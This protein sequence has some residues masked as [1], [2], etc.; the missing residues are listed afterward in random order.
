MSSKSRRQ[1]G[2]FPFAT[3]DP[4]PHWVHR[5]LLSIVLPVYNH[6]RFLREAIESVLRPSQYPLELIVINDGSTDPAV[7]DILRA[8][9]SR[10][11][12][13]VLR[14]PNRG[15]AR[16]LNRGFAEAQGSLLGWTSADNRYL[17]GALDRMADFLVANPGIGLV[18][19]N[20]QLI[21]E[22][23]LPAKASSYRPQDQDPAETSVLLLPHAA[24]TLDALND[25][26]VNACV[27]FRADCAYLAGPL[28]ARHHGYED[29]DHWLRLLRFRPFAHLPSEE[30]Y[31]QYRLHRESLT[32]ELDSS[33]L[34]QAQLTVVEH[35]R[36]VRQAL[37]QSL[38]FQI[39][40]TEREEALAETVARALREAGH[41][42]NREPAN[43]P[44]T[45]IV[46]TRLG[47]SGES[48]ASYRLQKG[49][50][51]SFGHSAH[52][53]LIPLAATAII[54][55]EHSDW[56]ELVYPFPVEVP[57]LL[58][59]ARDANYGAVSPAFGSIASLLLFTPDESTAVDGADFR[60]TEWFSA[61]MD[62]FLTSLPDITFVLFCQSESQRRLADR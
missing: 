50:G 11:G 35:S 30:P 31:Y 52:R 4:P 39:L 61:R 42:V 29:Y 45:G 19:A 60:A 53:A 1:P 3:T 2:L 48:A 38:S 46:V 33:K 6:A 47:E 24:D 32:A 15:L 13:R 55:H 9:E 41:R 28:E 17:P 36:R 20:V 7:E 18:Y 57:A 54:P 40:S 56:R 58:K 26:F 34:S 49:P 27:L 37:R 25:N 23:G 22:T 16:T 43:A 59:R 44:E 21:D 5:P 12:V 8:Y 51:G 62:D 10:P 14:H